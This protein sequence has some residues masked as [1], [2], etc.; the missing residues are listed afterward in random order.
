[1]ANA[2][3]DLSG[4]TVQNG[5]TI[6]WPPSGSS[7]NGLA[8]AEGANVVFPQRG[9]S[10]AS[11]ALPSG[12]ADAV[13]ALDNSGGA[14]ALGA[15]VVT[16]DDADFLACVVASLNAGTT[17]PEGLVAAVSGNAVR[18]V[19]PHSHTFTSDGELDIG[20]ASGWN[21]AD[22]AGKAVFVSGASTVALISPSSPTFSRITLSDGAT[23]KVTGADIELPPIT[24]LTP[25]TLLV[26]DGASAAMTNGFSAMGDASG[27]PVVKVETNG[28]LTVAWIIRHR[29]RS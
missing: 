28:V 2:V 14:F 7:V 19:T 11:G 29:A 6:C 8:L 17:V 21:M 10:A 22:F 25:S 20:D 13:F 5:A 1:M 4:V 16:S 3:A 9:A 26:P 24:L 18:L 15:T 27:L 23:L 12:Y